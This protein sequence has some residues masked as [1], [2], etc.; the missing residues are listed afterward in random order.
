MLC[1]NSLL[2]VM[3]F[4]RNEFDKQVIRDVLHMNCALAL[5]TIFEMGSS[6]VSGLI[7]FV[8]LKC[9]QYYNF[10]ISVDVRSAA[11]FQDVMVQSTLGAQCT[12]HLSYLLKMCG[13]FPEDESADGKD[14][15][16][17]LDERFADI[18][19]TLNGLQYPLEVQYF[20]CK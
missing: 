5:R 14:S 1:F 10:S 12:V 17:F 6:P 20:A 8:D 9:A 11:A 2:L 19:E 7:N 3:E 4:R 18:A 16:L 13:Y 15:S